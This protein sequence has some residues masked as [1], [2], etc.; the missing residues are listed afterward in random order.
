MNGPALPPPFDPELVVEELARS[1]T[2]SGYVLAIARVTKKNQPG[3]SRI[4][5]LVYMP[6][7]R[8]MWVGKADA[9][10]WI[11]CDAIAPQWLA[12]VEALQSEARRQQDDY[13]KALGE[14]K[15]RGSRKTN[16]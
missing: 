9:G 15:A 3:W 10:R 13:A 6:R 11:T 2:D 16:P 1:Q 14:R 4:R 5:V 8:G 12:V 7:T